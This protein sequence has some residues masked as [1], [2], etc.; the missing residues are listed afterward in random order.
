MDKETHKFV[1][2]QDGDWY[3]KV[4]LLMWCEFRAPKDAFDISQEWR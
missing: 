2:K 3:A 4:N 1:D